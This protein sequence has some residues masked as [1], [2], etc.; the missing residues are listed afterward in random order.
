MWSNP[1]T[2]TAFLKRQHKLLHGI[3]RKRLRNIPRVSLPFLNIAL[4]FVASPHKNHG[5][6]PETK[7][8]YQVLGLVSSTMLGSYDPFRITRSNRND[9]K[10]DTP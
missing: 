10:S 6:L 5:C 7:A 1:F 3:E 2:L 9:A 4:H 8:I